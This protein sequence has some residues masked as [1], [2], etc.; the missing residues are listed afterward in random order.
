MIKILHLGW[1]IGLVMIFVCLLDAQAQSARSIADIA[2]NFRIGRLIAAK[3]LPNARTPLTASNLYSLSTRSGS[4]PAENYE[5]K[6]TAKGYI[7]NINQVNPNDNSDTLFKVNLTYASD[8][9]LTHYNEMVVA[10]TGTN[11]YV[12]YKYDLQGR[13]TFGRVMDTTRGELMRRT[14]TWAT[15]GNHAMVGN[16]QAQDVSGQQVSYIIR[17]NRYLDVRGK[18]VRDSALKLHPRLGTFE[19]FKSLYQYDQQEDLVGIVNY[20]RNL[21]ANSWDLSDSVAFLY[22]NDTAFVQRWEGPALGNAYSLS[23]TLKY[24]PASALRGYQDRTMAISRVTEFDDDQD[25]F[26]NNF[27]GSTFK[28]STTPTDGCRITTFWT[29]HPTTGN[30]RRILNYIAYRL[31]RSTGTVDSLAWQESIFYDFSPMVVGLGAAQMTKVSLFPNPTQDYLMLKGA[32]LTTFATASAINA[33][34]QSISLNIDP[35]RNALDVRA[36]PAGCYQLMLTDQQG[37]PMRATFVK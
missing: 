10:S 22:R 32:E 31:R 25:L 21:P 29:T 35:S 26:A 6:V 36:L 1:V 16:L 33:Q 8:S 7:T 20:N 37:I 5:C 24:Y 11:G 2:H 34:G 19:R 23:Q 13:M 17:L 4:R 14:N 18:V 28:A 3:A 12:E 15:T 9:L 30:P 27:Y